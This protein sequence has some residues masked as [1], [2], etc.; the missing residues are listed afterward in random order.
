MDT[1]TSAILLAAGSGSRMQSNTK[2]QFMELAGK[3]VLYY[4]LKAL[5]ESRVEEILLVVA[6]ED[7]EHCRQLICSWGFRKVSRL[8]EGGKERWQ[9]VE[10]ALPFVTGSFCLIHDGARPLIRTEQINDLIR[11]GEKQ[12]GVILAVPVKDTIKVVDEKGA[13]VDTPDR[14][15]L[16]AAQTPQMFRTKLLS[17]AYAC[18]KQEKIPEISITDDAMLVQHYTGAMVNV[19]PGDYTN[20][21]VT[22]PEDLPLAEL[23]LKQRG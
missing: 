1:R 21:K 2:K 16:Y 19:Y 14:K 8:V 7:M 18:L 6:P 23:L 3:P 11:E 15:T 13:I 12:D 5:E 22:T 4:S 9:S 10:Q 17:R 20:L